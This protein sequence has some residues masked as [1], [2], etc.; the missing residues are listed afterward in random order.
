MMFQQIF[1]PKKQSPT[2]IKGSLVEDNAIKYL[3]AK[4]LKLVTR[5]FTGRQGEIDLIMKDRDIFVFIE[6]RLR[7]SS[8][9]GL[10][11][12]TVTPAKQA[13]IIKTATLYLQK[14]NLT[15]KVAC[16]FDVIATNSIDNAKNL[17]YC[18]IPNAFQLENY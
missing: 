5:N 14:N 2:Q 9:Y 4:K 3:Q 16:R 8:A 11:V 6:V 1:K 13:K 7:K 18:W 12:E 15:D 10:A 17:Q